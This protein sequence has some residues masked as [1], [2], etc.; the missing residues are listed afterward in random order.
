ME[1]YL[2]TAL[3]SAWYFGSGSVMGQIASRIPTFRLLFSTMGKFQGGEKDVTFTSF[4]RSN[5]QL[6]IG[7]CNDPRRLN[8]AIPRAKD[9]S[10]VVGDCKH[11]DGS[12]NNG[13]LWGLAEYCDK[14]KLILNYAD[15]C[16]AVSLSGIPVRR[17]VRHEHLVGGQA[18]KP[19]ATFVDDDVDYFQKTRCQCRCDVGSGVAALFV[20]ATSEVGVAQ[21]FGVGPI[22]GVIGL[23]LSVPSFALGLAKCE[24]PKCKPEK[25]LQAPQQLSFALLNAS[26]A[27]R[28][29]N[30]NQN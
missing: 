17:G 12:G 13:V 21:S 8:V 16:Q 10:I 3:R 27:I 1:F 20:C 15:S 30:N 14:R 29:V 23:V 11:F 19:K 24:A 22:R 26:Q 9:L 6:R 25:P 18:R 4:A 2:R 28:E 7:F 5:D